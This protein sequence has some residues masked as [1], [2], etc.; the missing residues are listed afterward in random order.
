MEFVSITNVGDMPAASKYAIVEIK[1]MNETEI[2]SA[3][4]LQAC[5]QILGYSH[6]WVFD[7]INLG[8]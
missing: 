1:S 4:Q 7:L 6:S 5:S 8:D 2:V 3:E